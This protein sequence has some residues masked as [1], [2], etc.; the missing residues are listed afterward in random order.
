M[1]MKARV[2]AF[3]TMV[4]VMAAAC[5]SGDVAGDVACSVTGHPRFSSVFLEGPQLTKGEFEATDVGRVLQ[6]FFQSE[7]WAVEG[8]FYRNARGFSIV[9]KSLVLVYDDTVPSWFVT[10]ENGR[11]SIGGGSCQPTRVSGRSVASQWHPTGD[12]D[13]D[14]AVIPIVVDGGGCVRNGKTEVTTRIVKIDVTENAERVDVVVWTK[15]KLPLL[16]CA[17]VGVSLDSEVTLSSPL[18]GRPL[19][20]AGLVPAVRVDR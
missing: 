15:E 18:D 7:E 6:S 3:A 16:G 9:S 4:T 8:A 17:S 14:S 11:V 10:V 12:L 13:R 19:Y 1:G 20:N 2:L 5:S